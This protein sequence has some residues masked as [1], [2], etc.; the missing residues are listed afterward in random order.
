MAAASSALVGLLLLLLVSVETRPSPQHE[1]RVCP[2]Y[3]GSASWLVGQVMWLMLPACLSRCFSLCSAL[4]SPP[5]SRPRPRLMTSQRAP[6]PRQ[7]P[8]LCCWP[9]VATVTW[10]DWLADRKWCPGSSWTSCGGGRRRG[11]GATRPRREEE[12]AS[13][14][15]WTASAPSAAW[16]ARDGY[17]GNT[18][19]S[20]NWRWPCMTSDL[21]AEISCWTILTR[22]GWAQDDANASDLWPAGCLQPAEICVTCRCV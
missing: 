21:Q 1:Q 18:A 10:A 17:H 9:W 16:A 2:S 14:W 20:R 13:G 15:S 7:P 4:A 22:A 8:R 11:G 19:A 3:C 5:S 6:P 12:D